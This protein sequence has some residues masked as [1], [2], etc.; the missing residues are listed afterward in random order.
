ME[1]TFP[2][3]KNAMVLTTHKWLG[4]SISRWSD[5][6]KPAQSASVEFSVRE[7]EKKPPSL[8]SFIIIDDLLC[9]I[10]ITDGSLL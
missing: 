10:I 7:L 2:V 4:I 8:I 1:V 5:A 9:N 6:E 3:Q